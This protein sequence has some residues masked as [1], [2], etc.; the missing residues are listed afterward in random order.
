MHFVRNWL[1][2]ADLHRGR[3]D[4][5]VPGDPRGR[6]SGDRGQ[7]SRSACRCTDWE[8]CCGR[9]GSATSTN[10][11]F[12]SV[13]DAL[14]LTLY[15]LSYAG[16]VGL[17]AAARPAH[18]A[19][20]GLARRP[21]RRGGTRRARRGVRVRTGP[22]L[23]DR[24]PGRRGDRA[25][26]SDLRSPARRPDGRGPR[27]ARMARRPHMGAA[28]GAASCCSP[29]PTACTPFRSRAARAAPAR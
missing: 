22:G 7:S 19:G 16:I 17:R 21:D 24:Q 2:S 12:P 3:G 6:P 13:S 27:S 5:R 15:P 18:R 28:W 10:P 29:W 26:L 14:W 4:R 11:P 23:G 20:R 25:G 9:S 8:T 1:S